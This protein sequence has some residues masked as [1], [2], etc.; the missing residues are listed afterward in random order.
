MSD[1]ESNAA[2]L[3]HGQYLLMSNKRNYN[4]SDGTSPLKLGCKK[5]GGLHLGFVSLPFGCFA[6]REAH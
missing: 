1:G 6:L 4:K 3:E 2:P 5:D